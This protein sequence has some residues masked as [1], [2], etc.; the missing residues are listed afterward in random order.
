MAVIQGLSSGLTGATMPFTAIA[1][2]TTISNTALTADWKSA[3]RHLIGVMMHYTQLTGSK[4]C[5][6]TLQCSNDGSTWH[7]FTSNTLQIASGVAGGTKTCARFT[8]PPA[9]WYRLSVVQSDD[10]AAG[11]VGIQVAATPI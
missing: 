2:G 11:T 5:T 7:D 8:P 10:T 9:Q 1:A 3:D 6:V 4:T